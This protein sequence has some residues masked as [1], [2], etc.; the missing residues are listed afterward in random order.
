MTLYQLHFH[1]QKLH[2]TI[3]L[4][5]FEHEKTKKIYLWGSLTLISSSTSIS[6]RFHKYKSMR[7]FTICFI[8]PGRHQSLKNGLIYKVTL[9]GKFQKKKRKLSQSDILLALEPFPRKPFVLFLVNK[10][11]VLLHLNSRT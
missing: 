1:A 3:Y 5:Y 2:I 7:F 4:M 8:F 9:S 6:S 10:D 11:I